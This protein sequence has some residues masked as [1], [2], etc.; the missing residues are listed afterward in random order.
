MSSIAASECFTPDL[1]DQPENRITFYPDLIYE[2]S[3]E[4]DQFILN[5]LNVRQKVVKTTQKL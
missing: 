2:T 1:S 5:L 4:F 3:P